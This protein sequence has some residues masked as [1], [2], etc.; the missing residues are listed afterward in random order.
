MVF[1][2]VGLALLHPLLEAA[3]ILLQVRA[4]QKRVG[5]E[6]FAHPSGHGLVHEQVREVRRLPGSV[7]A[8][9]RL[10]PICLERVTVGLDNGSHWAPPISNQTSLILN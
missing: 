4:L 10:G 2:D 3:P 9:E 7:R 8:R 5:D 1:I 6:V